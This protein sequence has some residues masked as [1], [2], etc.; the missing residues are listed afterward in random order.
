MPAAVL[1]RTQ[2]GLS[3]VVGINQP[4]THN[5]QNTPVRSGLS[6]AQHSVRRTA[7]NP[8]FAIGAEYYDSALAA[9]DRGCRPLHRA[10]RAIR[11]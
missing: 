11:N 10:R 8:Q 6:C 9:L 4:L 5:A 2:S 1:D 3:G 7:G